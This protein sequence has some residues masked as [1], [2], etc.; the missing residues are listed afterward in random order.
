M[1]CSGFDSL[2]EHFM[3]LTSDPQS[4]LVCR[5]VTRIAACS[6]RS[7]RWRSGSTRK[8]DLCPRARAVTLSPMTEET[9]GP[10]GGSGEWQS[11]DSTA[12][13]DYFVSYL[14][15]GAAVL[16]ETRMEIMRHLELVPGCSVLDVGSGAGEF[17]IEAASSVELARAVGIDISEAMVNN[18]TSRARKAGVAVQFALGDAQRLD[19]PDES[20]DRVNCS[21]VL[22]HLDDPAAAI[23]EMTRVLVP[24]GRMAISEPDFDAMMIDSD[25]LD[26]AGVVRRRGAARL[27]NPDIGRRLRRLLLASRLELLR[28]TG[29]AFPVTSLQTAVDQFRILDRLEDAVKAGE[30][31]VDEA[32]QWRG[33]LEAVDEADRLFI[34]PVL[35]QAIARKPASPL[36]T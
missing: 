32:T 8:R 14:D 6:D 21:R 3:Y 36:G 22:M 27:R 17:L 1:S 7:F 13:P 20:F 24:G 5:S 26:I 15:R 31:G 18:A 12:D 30:V 33:W 28:L 16:R 11:V 35:F 10:K 23:A 9:S 29:L 34:A 2:R 4:G 19:F 25:N